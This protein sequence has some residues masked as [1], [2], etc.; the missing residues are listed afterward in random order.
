MTAQL[1]SF[2][3]ATG[4]LICSSSTLGLICCSSALAEITIDM[5]PGRME[6]ERR[7]LRDSINQLEARGIG[8][9]SYSKAFAALNGDVKSNIS[10]P[11]LQKRFDKLMSNVTE[12]LAK[13][14]LKDRLESESK[15]PFVPAQPTVTEFDKYCDAL[16]TKFEK[17]LDVSAIKDEFAIIDFSIKPDGTIYGVVEDKKSAASA[18]TH[19]MLKAQILKVKNAG[20]PPG[21]QEPLKMSAIWEKRIKSI[22][23]TEE[24]YNDIDYSA[25]MRTAQQRIKE[26]WQPPK[27]EEGKQVSVLFVVNRKGELLTLEIAKSSDSNEA[28]NAVLN[29]VRVAAPFGA[30]PEGAPPHVHIR[31]TFVYN[32]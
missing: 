2:L 4:A 10:Q 11:E 28:D 18:A 15:K 26:A 21:R 16:E 7:A 23:V 27:G 5:V 12:Q 20:M 32:K 13:L 22:D 3:L 1:R 9:E 31:F 14:A 30:L 29:A 24:K 17:D 6:T 19:E 8:V 25:Y